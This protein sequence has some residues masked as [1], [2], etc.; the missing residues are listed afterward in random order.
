MKMGIRKFIIVLVISQLTACATNTALTNPVLVSSSDEAAAVLI[1]VNT[2]APWDQIADAVQPNFTLTGDQ[3][4]Q[5]IAPTTTRIQEQVLSAFGVSLG[6]GLSPGGLASP[7]QTST[8]T[9]AGGQLP[10]AP[11]VTGDI[12]LDPILK[13]QSALALY[14]SVQLMNREVQYAAVR[15]GFVP[16][17]VTMKF[18]VMPYRRNL[19]YDIHARISFFPGVPD[20]VDNSQ[21]GSGLGQVKTVDNSHS[22]SGGVPVRAEKL[23]NMVSGQVGIASLGSGPGPVGAVKLGN[24]VPES[25]VS[26]AKSSGDG[27]ACT[28]LSQ[29]AKLPQVLPIL[30]TDDIERALKSRAVEMAQ[31][32]GLALSASFQS[33]GGSLGLNKVNQTLNAISGQDI[34]SRLT[35]TRQSDNTIYVRIGASYESTAGLALVGQTYNVSLLLLVPNEYF[36][37]KNC[38][39]EIKVF[40]HNELRNALDGTI[41]ASRPTDTFVSQGDKAIN[42]TLAGE[43]NGLLAKWNDKKND[44]REKNLN[45]LA[46]PIQTSSFAE[47]EQKLN[48]LGFG[49]IKIDFKKAL[50]T[51]LSVILADSSFKTHYFV[52]PL[53]PSIVFEEQTPLLLDDNKDKSQVQLQVLSEA[54]TSKMMGTLKLSKRGTSKAYQLLA[55]KIDLNV[56]TGVFTLTFPSLAKSGIGA[57]KDYDIELVIGQRCSSSDTPCENKSYSFNPIYMPVKVENTETKLAFEAE[58]TKIVPTKSGSY[59]T[60][61][62]DTLKNDF[63]WVTVHDADIDKATDS[64]GAQLAITNHKVKVAKPTTITF[65]LRNLNAGIQFTIQAEGY[66][67]SK[68]T[69]KKEIQF[70]V[71]GR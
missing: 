60:V 63:A 2:V 40:M 4:L 21:S 61:T 71:V 38:S 26:K 69:G 56:G 34:N 10:T 36:G 16:Y 18:A 41:L 9:P 33:V 53:M 5:Q 35:V 13:Y 7:P 11:S 54:P 64:S 28:T 32:I 6:L 37:G 27:P 22:G 1:S 3:A 45:E 17:L 15:D 59:A 44:E 66:T 48:E 20:F 52:L 30:V 12:G 29:T 23:G 25:S 70:N 58:V 68:S 14:Q 31:Q 8:N 67:G 24:V 51:R 47:F 65:H 50:W 39:P 62:I 19:P 57:I 49:K 55:Q 42:V 46:H 43:Y